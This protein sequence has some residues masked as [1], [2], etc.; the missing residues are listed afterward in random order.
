MKVSDLK[1]WDKNPRKI[2]AS[3]ARI[4]A[5]TLRE[6]GDLS[7]IVFNK[8]NGQLVSGHQR[9]EALGSAEIQIVKGYDTP[10]K[11]GTVAVGW[12]VIDGEVHYYREVW[13]DEKK[14]AAAAIAANKSAGD[15][16]WAQLKDIA[17]DLDD[18]AFDL[19]LT[20]FDLIE[21]ENMLGKSSEVSDDA[22]VAIGSKEY[23][24][25][26]F[27]KFDHVCPRCNFSFNPIT[28]NEE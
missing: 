28:K 14:H 22:K 17:L 13:F 15:W 9:S 7:G 4:L 19:E 27:Q 18:G 20:G 16:D 11:Q 10:T 23:G 25:E 2:T 6:Y 24:E 21:L 3:K 8:A 1:K 5:K 12:A 26:E